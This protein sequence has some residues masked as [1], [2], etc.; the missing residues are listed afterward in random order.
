MPRRDCHSRQLTVPLP[1]NERPT[2]VSCSAHSR[3]TP[4]GFE[5]ASPMLVRPHPLWMHVVSPCGRTSTPMLLGIHAD[6]RILPCT[7]TPFAF[8][9]KHYTQN[10]ESITDSPDTP[11]ILYILPTNP[12]FHP[13]RSICSLTR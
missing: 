8:L 12:L 5:S 6:K 13:L 7:Y 4:Y 11:I 2:T 1:W 3:G 9:L 10:K